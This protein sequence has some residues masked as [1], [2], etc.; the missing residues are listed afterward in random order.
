MTNNKTDKKIYSLAEIKKMLVNNPSLMSKLALEIKKNQSEQI[1]Q[2]SIR[3]DKSV[4]ET[5]KQVADKVGVKS[6]DAW[7]EAM[8]LFIRKYKG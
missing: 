7:T 1:T 3:C 4:L 5:F 6:Q 8:Q 2:T